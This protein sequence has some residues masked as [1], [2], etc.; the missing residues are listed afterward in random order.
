MMTDQ[1]LEAQEDELL[2]LA[3]I[4][5]Q[6]EF[7]RAKLGGEIRVSMD[8]PQD[9]SLTVK[10]GDRS[11]TISFLPPVILTF[12]LPCDY[13]STSSPEFILSCNWL[14]HN[15]LSA[16]CRQLDK[17][18]QNIVGS[19]VLF[20]WVKF[21]R[22]DLLHF[23]H[24]QSPLEI[25]V[26]DQGQATPSTK[27]N[28]AWASQRVSEDNEAGSSQRDSEDNEAGASHRVSED[29]E[30]GASHRVSED[31]EAGASHRVSEDNGAVASH[32]VSEDNGAVASHRVSEDRDS[33]ASE[34]TAVSLDHRA[35][36]ELT[37]DTDLLPML[38]DYNEREKQRVFDGQAHDCG[39]CFMSKLGC[40][41]FRECGHVYC[42]ECMSEFFTIQIT[43]G[44]VHG[45]ICPEA[46]CSST[47]TPSQVRQLVGVELFDR[48][49]RLLLQSSLDRMPDVMY[50]PRK[51]CATP[52]ILDPNHTDALCPSCRYAFCKLCQK[53]YHGASKCHLTDNSV[54]N[55]CPTYAYLPKTE[56]GLRNLWEDY[57]SGNR[58]RRR[59]LENRYGKHTMASVL[60]EG[61]SVVWKEKNSK[62]CP[63]CSVNIQKDGG[64]EKMVCLTC[65]QYFCWQC[66]VILDRKDPY[67][68]FNTPH[69][70]N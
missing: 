2:A 51:T 7:V 14:S 34:G 33:V 10:P 1:D 65:G 53:T 23:L 62:N 54:K 21:L 19:V 31:N 29:N 22:D 16:V 63:S 45:L 59:L 43:E 5:S 58:Q 28:V 27:D 36:S 44:N 70:N 39:I 66:L 12:N 4:Y 17:I 15:Q 55:P 24:L 6:G 48:Y 18:W 13:P 42:N 35:I 40:S 46:D 69:N 61:L 68:H 38:L 64:C 49:D 67:S 37:R 32:R 52:V 25:P 8:L 50:C 41:Q 47:A 3:S 26:S 57:D 20:Y 56:V 30:A 11:Y 60:E 9:F